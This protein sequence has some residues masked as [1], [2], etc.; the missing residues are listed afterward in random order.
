MVD[1]RRMGW[2][3][4]GREREEARSVV[5]RRRRGSRGRAVDHVSRSSHFIEEQR[6]LPWDTT[7]L[8]VS[9]SVVEFAAS[10]VN[11]EIRARA[12]RTSALQPKSQ[13]PL[14]GTSSDMSHS[15][16]WVFTIGAISFL[17]PFLVWIGRVHRGS[18]DA[19][20]W[21]GGEQDFFRRLIA[22]P[23][24]TLRRHTKLL[25]VI[26]FAI[27]IGIVWLLP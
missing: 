17:V 12:Q 18:A 11:Q 9:F 21:R 3:E 22:R 14:S 26:W 1:D 20:L 10:L 13:A 5:P 16:R 27:W 8:G 15:V 2:R 24:G 7:H 4:S 6:F 19:G 25:T 23:D